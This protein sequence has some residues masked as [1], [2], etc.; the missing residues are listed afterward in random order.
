MPQTVGV[1]FLSEYLYLIPKSKLTEDVSKVNTEAYSKIVRSVSKMEG[2][3]YKSS[4]KKTKVLYKNAYCI[5]SS[6]D[7]T[8]VADK[9]EGFGDGLVQYCILD[10]NTFGKTN[11]KI[12]YYQ[13][14]EEVA[15]DFCS[16]SAISYGPIKAVEAGNLHT[17]LL[18][19][20]CGD[21]VMVYVLVM[22][23]YPA[24]SL[25]QKKFQESFSARLD[26]VC[27]WFIKQF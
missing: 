19:A 10:D 23:K 25:L 20:D 14:E 24:I 7:T 6:E 17:E 21:Y 27:N 11:Y 18:I 16:T 15:C 22:T 3:L 9:T 8:R 1:P 2:M 5:K 26:A 13:N 12:M 4:P